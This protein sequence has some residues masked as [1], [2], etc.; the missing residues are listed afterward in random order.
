[1][2]NAV[3]H[4]VTAAQAREVDSARSAQAAVDD[5]TYFDCI[6]VEDKNSG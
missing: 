6:I 1:M 3:S 2:G 4:L 5:K